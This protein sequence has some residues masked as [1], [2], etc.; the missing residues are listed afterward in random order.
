MD[1]AK[2]S[3]QYLKMVLEFYNT[4]FRGAI[5][6][7]LYA[8]RVNT[9]FENKFILGNLSLCISLSYF[10]FIQKWNTTYS[11]QFVSVV[12]LTNFNQ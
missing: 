5:P 3:T 7:H 8:R 2:V 6:P 11:L 1:R 10:R 12:I 9:T 4:L